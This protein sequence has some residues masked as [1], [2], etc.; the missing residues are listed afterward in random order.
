MKALNAT[1]IENAFEAWF[2]TA[3]VLHSR[4]TLKYDLPAGEEINSFT[5]LVYYLDLDCPDDE[6]S[7][8]IP[9]V[10]GRVGLHEKVGG[11][12]QGDH[13]HAV[14]KLSVPG[15]DVRYFMLA[16]YHASHDGT[17]YD[18]GFTEVKPIQKVVDD[19]AEV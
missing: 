7:M 17:C 2:E 16:G 14:L 9:G 10:E 19:W 6:K 18:E 15:Q 1:E 12:G 4:Y 11:E 5:D 13:A 8:Q 3:P